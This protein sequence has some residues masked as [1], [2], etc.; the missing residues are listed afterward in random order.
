MF[1]GGFDSAFI[2][3]GKPIY[4]YTQIPALKAQ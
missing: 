2:G 4:E 1:R 3:E